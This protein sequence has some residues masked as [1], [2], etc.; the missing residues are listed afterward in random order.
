MHPARS[1]TPT[2]AKKFGTCGFSVDEE[3]EEVDPG[4]VVNVRFD[5]C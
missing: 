5:I 2:K 3:E 4:V 1:P